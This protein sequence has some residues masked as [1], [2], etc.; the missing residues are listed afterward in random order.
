[1]AIK[2]GENSALT[3]AQNAALNQAREYLKRQ[4]L[5]PSPIGTI[6][7]N[8]KG[9]IEG[10]THLNTMMTTRLSLVSAYG[11][12]SANLLNPAVGAAGNDDRRRYLE[13][14]GLILAVLA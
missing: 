4:L 2:V 14:V 13:C 1:M 11:W 6:Y 12:N 5:S 9:F 8:V 10:N 7:S 3:S